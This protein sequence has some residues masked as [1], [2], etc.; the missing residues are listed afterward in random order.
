MTPHQTLAI[1]VAGWDISY[2]GDGVIGDFVAVRKTP[3]TEYQAVNG[4][5]ERM[6][7]DDAG[8]LFLLCEAQRRLAESLSTAEALY[9]QAQKHRQADLEKRMAEVRSEAGGRGDDVGSEPGPRPASAQE[10]S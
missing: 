10:T 2:D 5:M 1:P 8:E 6:C 3:L 7:A 4:A 9:W